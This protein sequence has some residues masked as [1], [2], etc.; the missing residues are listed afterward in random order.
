MSEIK[1]SI[2][3]KR[4]RHPP[5]FLFLRT[6]IS[7]C[8][9]FWDFLAFSLMW[10]AYL[11]FFYKKPEYWC[12]YVDLSRFN[13]K[14]VLHRSKCICTCKS[15]SM[16]SYVVIKY[17]K[18]CQTFRS[19]DISRRQILRR[20][21][22]YWLNSL[23][24]H[25]T[26]PFSVMKPFLRRWRCMRGRLKWFFRWGSWRGWYSLDITW[27]YGSLRSNTKSLTL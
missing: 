21:C 4:T 18:G 7:K 5:P 9:G 20:Y 8:H 6:S 17:R 15:P 26:W 19:L 1:I 27:Q 11:I 16:S 25:M 22:R 14:Y 24:L 23:R 13:T 3:F 12:M 2:E 10:P